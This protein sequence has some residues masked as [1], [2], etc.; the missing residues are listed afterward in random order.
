MALTYVRS[1]PLA[2]HTWQKRLHRVKTGLKWAHFTCLCTPKSPRSLVE[3]HVFDPFL[4]HYWSPNG[5]FSKHFG[6]SK[7]P[8]RIPMGSQR[9]KTLV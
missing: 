5:P 1:V 9:A 3:K 8:K 2:A 6:I 7:G 4:T